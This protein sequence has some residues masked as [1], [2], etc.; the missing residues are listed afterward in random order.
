MK[1]HRNVTNC[2]VIVG[3]A[4]AAISVPVQHVM[5]AAFI[6][7]PFD[8][9]VGETLNGSSGGIGFLDAWT[10]GSYTGDYD[11]VG[12]GN[13]VTRTLPASGNSLLTQAPTQFYSEDDRSLAPAI[14]G[15]PGSTIYVSFLMRKDGNGTAGSDYFGLALFQAGAGKPG[16]FIGDPGDN[17]FYS[18]GLV[19]S[20][21]GLVSSTVTSAVSSTPT[22]LVVKITFALGNDTFQLF[23]NPDPAKGEPTTA[24]ATKRDLDLTD[25]ES[26]AIISG[27]NAVW[28]ADE[29]RIGASYADVVPTIAAPTPTPTP[30]PAIGPM[31]T[32]SPNP[33]PATGQLVNISTRLNVGTG[34]DV[35]IGGFILQGNSTKELIVRGI[36]PSLTSFGVPNA[37]QDPT[38]ELRDGAGALIAANDN[39]KSDQ[40]QAVLDSGLAPM[41]DRE[42]AIDAVLGPGNYTAIVRG[43]SNTTGVGL[44]ELY[45]VET[46]A[47][48]AAANISTRGLVQPGDNVMIGGIIIQ[49]ATSKKVVIRG[50]GPSL[51]G[52]GISNPIPDPVLELH[53]GN[54][55]LLQQNDD[56][57]S[58]QQQQ[59]LGTGLAPTND[60][61]SA[62]VATLSAGSYTAILRGKSSA[63]GVGLV[64]VYGL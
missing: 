40:Q 22:F 23:V 46:D 26:I 31:A 12:T 30:T 28:S 20:G 49:G 27:A 33:T 16:L 42:S 29:I 3:V 25:I 1:H 38:L 48:T 51:A 5:A 4:V 9:S 52:F 45:D 17:D 50:L 56:W 54:G 61:E 35:L 44:V 53:D 63:T 41:S 8:Y 47:S 34:N 58:D 37:L 14:Q 57:R 59:I 13:L 60:L 10:E 64:E 36:G 21:V 19:G 39:W 62:I 55:A 2:L 43:V 15:T 6:S 7:E 11:L 18:I 32:P 24:S